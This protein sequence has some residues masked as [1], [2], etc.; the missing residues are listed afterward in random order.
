MS[1]TKGNTPVR[2]YAIPSLR[3]RIEVRPHMWRD[4]GLWYCARRPYGPGTHVESIKGIGETKHEAWA[5]WKVKDQRRWRLPR[6]GRQNKQSARSWFFEG[7][8]YISSYTWIEGHRV[9]QQ[10]YDPTTDELI[11]RG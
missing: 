2:R 8:F 1:I 9:I 3:E 6:A 10:G 11:Y 5:Q 4:G 7:C